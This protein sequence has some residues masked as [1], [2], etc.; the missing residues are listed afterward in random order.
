MKEMT[1]VSVAHLVAIGGAIVGVVV[2]AR[3]IS[4]AIRVALEE[5][6]YRAGDLESWLR[7]AT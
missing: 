3:V 6:D 7:R 1:D 2:A 4:A 5:L